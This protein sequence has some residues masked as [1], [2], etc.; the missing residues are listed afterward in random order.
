LY[1]A[2]AHV[3]EV[4]SLASVIGEEELSP[5]DRQFL[6]FG[7]AFEHEF[8]NQ[9]PTENRSMEQTLNIGWRL[10]SILPLEE[11][12]RVSAEEIERYYEGEHVQD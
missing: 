8:I 11:L 12:T 9:S 4:R 10:L 2:Y 5:I 7:R 1:A 3:Q 6:Q